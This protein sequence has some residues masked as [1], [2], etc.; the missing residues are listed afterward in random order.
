MTHALDPRR[1]SEV[2]ASRLAR[3][4]APRAYPFLGGLLFAPAAAIMLSLVGACAILLR[5]SLN[6]W[7]PV[8]T[9]TPDVTAANYLALAGSSLV[10]LAFTNTLRISATVTAV[11]LVFGY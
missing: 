2:A 8:R 5:Y 9:M 10:G 4:A 11:C 3:P 6:S 7:D 1:G